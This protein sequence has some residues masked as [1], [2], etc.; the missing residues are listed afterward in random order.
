[1]AKLIVADDHP[2]FRN[3]LINAIS[4]TFATKATVETDSFESTCAAL[5]QH[6]D[7][8]LLLLDLHMPGNCG[9]LGLIQLRKNYPSLPIVVISA[10]EDLD[11]IRRVMSFGASAYVPKS[12]NPV[13]ISTALNAVLDGELWVPK[14]LQKQILEQGDT[15][16]DL[17]LASRVAQLTQQQYKVLYYLTEGW[18][19]KQIAYDLHISEATVK[20][21]ITAI[22]R[23]LGCTNRTQVVI[24]AQ[25]LTLEPPVD[26]AMAQ[27]Q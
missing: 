24:Q 6:P 25:R 17:D 2:L 18:L 19:N 22:F 16:Q 21:H 20:A 8:D 3:A 4:S 5:E 27:Q 13:D 1:M 15:E 26:R 14:N 23:K 11:V 9:F 10:S 7:A 12:A